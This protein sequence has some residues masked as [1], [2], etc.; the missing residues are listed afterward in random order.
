MKPLVL[1]ESNVTYG[2]LIL[3]TAA[4]LGLA[5]PVILAHS[6]ERYAYAAGDGIELIPVDTFSDDTVHEACH[7]L[8]PLAG[9][10]AGYEYMLPRAA[11]IARRLGLISPEPAALAACIDKLSQRETLLAHGV[12]MPR[13][14][15]AATAPA[16][17][18]AA[19]RIGYP[20]V[21]K[22]RRTAASVGTRLCATAAEVAAHATFL[23][24]RTLNER[25]HPVPPGMLVEEYIPL[26]DSL[27]AHQGTFSAAISAYTFG[28]T[29]VGL[30]R[31]HWSPL[32]WF[33]WTGCEYPAALPD[34]VRQRLEQATLSLLRA[35]RLTSGPNNVEFRVLPAPGGGIAAKMIEINPR[36]PGAGVTDLIR[37]ATGVDMVEA[38]LRWLI[39]DPT[40]LNAT[41]RRHAAIRYVLARQDGVIER[42][43]GLEEARATPGVV[44]ARCDLPPGKTLQLQHD[45]RDCVG[46][47]VAVAADMP[48]AIAVAEAARDRIALVY[49]PG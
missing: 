15:G 1:V 43:M 37:L 35:A 34:A 9:L 36:L 24:G 16:A 31:W 4:R 10:W 29:V 42:I 30:S 17:V 7:K 12:D 39:G 45:T 38:T 40:D 23:A 2:R 47:A 3:Q 44:D 41:A 14:E 33:L 6:P 46:F 26:D 19:D 21:L 22:P 27:P 11:R 28:E 8:G 5:R 48:A 49:R 20:V 18:A 32:P 25:G 13:F